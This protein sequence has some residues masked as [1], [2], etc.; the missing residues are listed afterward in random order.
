MKK[1]ALATIFLFSVLLFSPFLVKA[2]EEGQMVDF[3]VDPSYDS[4]ERDS[5]MATLRY[6]RDNLYFYIDND[7]WDKFGRDREQ[8][9][10]DSLEA[11]SDSFNNEIY[12]ILTSTYGSEWKPGIDEDERITVLFH[13]MRKQAAGYFR[14]GDEYSKLQYP[15]SNEREMVYLSTDYI[16]DDRLKSFL[17]HEFVH[18]VTFNQKDKINGAGE[19]IWLNEARAEHAPTLLGFDED[20]ENSNLR[21]RVKMFLDYPSDSLTEWKG[22]LADYGVLN[23]FTQYLVEKYGVEILTN[24]M[25]SSKVGIASMN[26]ALE[27]A[28]YQ[29][30]FA[31]VFRDWLITVLVNDCSFGNDYCY[32]NENLKSLKIS[33][34]LNF[35]PFVTKTTLRVEDSI[36]DWSGRWYKLI[37][38]KGN[39]KVEFD[40]A[41]RVD[42]NVFYL[43]CQ[44]T[45]DCSIEGLVLN[46]DQEG[47]ITINDF[48]A[49]YSY[50]TLIILTQEKTEDFGALEIPHSFYFEVLTEDN[51]QTIESLLEQIA[52]LQA[53]IAKIQA[54]IAAILEG[55]SECSTFNQNLYFGMTN[56]NQVKCLQQF[57]KSQG[58]DIYP[59]ELITGNFLS[60][61]KEAVIRFQEK[62][63]SEILSPLDL[64]RGTGYFGSLTRK[65]ANKLLK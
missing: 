24:S 65:L 60:L 45:G 50:L 48:G 33:P 47:Q 23:I 61:T 22:E 55:W 3:F 56:N 14:S 40:G 37:G 17:A 25:S 13:P 34:S 5:S 26:E 1:K 10:R 35:L 44:K 51:N 19:D 63:S 8:E 28:G 11:L 49:D 7:W 20:F 32:E 58:E 15:S 43:K 42:F 41:D 12:P 31:Q 52:Y 9:V 64:S 53:E 4:N 59:E 57:L 29:K 27:E 46:D 16:T 36:K 2:D 21:E 38:G 6:K 62:Y 54:Q 39:L 18:L 30:D